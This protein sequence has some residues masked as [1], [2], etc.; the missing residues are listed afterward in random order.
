MTLSRNPVRFVILFVGRSGSTNLVEALDSHSEISAS[1]EWLVGRDGDRQLRMTRRFLT[2]PPRGGEYAAIGFKTKVKEVQDPEGFA[3]LL[4]EAGARIIFLQRRNSIKHVV[5]RFN[6]YRLHGVTRN[7]NLYN[8]DDRLPPATIDLMWFSGNLEAIEE[9]KRKLESYVKNLGLP[10]LS[11]YYED[12]LY[13]RRATL[14]RVFSFLGLRFEP[15]QGGS[16][17]NTNDDLREAVSNFDELRSHYVGTTYEQMFDETPGSV[18][19]H[20]QHYTHAPHKRRLM[21]KSVSAVPSTQRKHATED[22]RYKKVYRASVRFWRRWC[23]DS[24]I[25]K[26]KARVREREWTRTLRGILMLL[27]YYSR[28]LAPLRKRR[29]EQNKLAQELQA[30]EQRVEELRGRLAKAH[31]RIKRLR[32]QNQRLILKAQNSGQQLQDMQGPES[33]DYREDST[34]SEPKY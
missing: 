28:R 34:M 3:E 16:I 11:L 7:W 15:V 26:A 8:E 14:G 30:H 27:R 13:E 4:R 1:G 17:K 22:Q 10:T 23:G 32:K 9:E 24:Q 6:S 29:M 20:R 2:Q 18:Q 33:G 31:H 12:L 21:S 25:D 5:S 19:N